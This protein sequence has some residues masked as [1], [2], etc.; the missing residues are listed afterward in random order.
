MEFKKLVYGV[1]INDAGRPVYTKVDGKRVMC[2]FYRRWAE[3]LRRCYDP[4]YHLRQPTYLGCSVAE[5]WLVFSGFESWMKTQDWEGK[6]LDKDLL[7]VGNKLYS[8]DLCIFV[9][10]KLNSFTMDCGASSGEWPVGAYLDKRR[11]RFMARC[12]NPFTGKKESLGYYDTPE[13]AHL[14]WKKR[15]HELALIYANQQ[16]DPRVAEALRTRYL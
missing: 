2:P 9:P 11:G 13:E 16:T 4:N 7:K 12:R 10:K 1:G 14:A 8:P 15:K 3:M 6:E 5:E